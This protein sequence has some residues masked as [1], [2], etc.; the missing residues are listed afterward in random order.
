MG[1]PKAALSLTDRA[2]TF[3]LRILRTC[4][5]A[6]LADI[7]VVT[8]STDD[9]VRQAAGRVDRRVRFV[10]NPEWPTGQLSSLLK[11]LR[12]VVGPGFS[13]A[14]RQLEA[15][16]VTPVD[17]PSV[18]PDTVRCVLHAWRT[19]GAPIVRP[20]RGDLHGHPV[21]FD[22]AVFEEIR[23]A[24]PHIGAKA[25]VRAHEREILNVPIDDEG[26]FVDVDTVEEYRALKA[27]SAAPPRD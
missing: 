5:S 8:G 16:L 20:A 4:A 2:D 13:L 19:T 21:I 18:S 22:R 6:G 27:L 11:G 26:A 17:V 7:V 25:V 15:A 24:D 14:D 9:A 12:T 23:A 3:L 1:R 10:Y